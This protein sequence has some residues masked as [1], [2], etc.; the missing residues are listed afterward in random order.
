MGGDA[1]IASRR[2]PGTPT[3]RSRDTTPKSHGQSPAS[4]DERRAEGGD[5]SNDLARVLDRRTDSHRATK[6]RRAA[7]DA[8]LDAVLSSS[9]PRADRIGSEG[10]HLLMKSLA[11][12]ERQEDI[13]GAVAWSLDPED[14]PMVLGALPARAATR[15]EANATSYRALSNLDRVQRL[16]DP[17]L[18]PELESLATRGVSAAAPIAGLGDT[19]A[20]ILLVYPTKIGRPLR[21]R[22]V[23]VLGEV[24]AKLGKT[25]STSLALERMTR[26][27]EAVRRLDRLAALGGLVSEIVHEIRNPLVSVKTF[28]QL[29]PDRL[30]DPEFHE[31]FRGVVEDEVGRLE[32]MLE[33]LLRHAR[34]TPTGS[35][36]E[37][38]ARIAN[39]VE[40]TLQ[41]LT[42][43]SREKGVLLETEIRDELPALAL[44]E[45]ALRQLMMNL[46]LNATEVTPNG[47]RIRV[48]AD[49]SAVSA[50]HVSIVVQDEGPGLDPAVAARVFE[51]FWTTRSDGNGG[52]GLAICKRIIEDAGGTIEL[53]ESRSTGARFRIE[54]PI[55]S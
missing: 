8:L 27:D 35:P 2:G 24:A 14:R 48:E 21:P 47:G 19:P 6:R 46:V 23:A 28:L 44:P 34:P 12:L 25:L 42:Y 52:L 3:S 1:N 49:W 10:Q 38:D 45:D 9:E 36:F 31:G 11:R 4:R 29:L 51:P 20:A 55:A 54:L 18:D 43:R 33:D 39:A 15:I 22:T 5:G 41:L 13:D 16:T 50:N 17:D 7:E 32:R 40:T 30:D 53:E 37:P 26:L